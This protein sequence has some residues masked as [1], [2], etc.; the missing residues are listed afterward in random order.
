LFLA[1]VI[2]SNDKYFVIFL[3]KPSRCVTIIIIYKF[4][5]YTTTIKHTTISATKMAAMRPKYVAMNH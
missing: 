5:S 1:K 2:C 4:T 3:R